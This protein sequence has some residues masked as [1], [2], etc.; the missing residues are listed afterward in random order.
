MASLRVLVFDHEGRPVAFDM[1]HDDLQLYLL[2]DIKDNVS[3]FGHVSG[4]AQRTAQA[5]YDA[6]VAR[7][8]SSATTASPVLTTPGALSLVTT[9]SAPAGRI[10][11]GIAGAA[12]GASASG[13]LPRT[14]P[15]EALHTFTLDSG[16]SPCFVSDGTTLTPLPAPVPVKQAD[17]SR[18]LVLA[19]SSTVLPCLGVSSGSLSGL[20]LP[21][22]STNL[23]S[24]AALQD[25][26]VTTT[27]PGGSSLYTL[28][29]EPPQGCERY[30]LLVVD[31]YSRYTTVF[32][33]RSKGEVVDV[34]IP[35]IPTVHLQLREHFGTDLRVLRLH[36]D[37]G[38]EFSSYLLREFF[39]GRAFSSR[40]R[41]RT[42]LSKMGLLSAALAQSWRSLVPP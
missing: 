27:T 12:L 28:A 15:A 17:P 26:M 38:S 6:V 2:S 24:T 36:S 13:T 3:L 10:C 39:V 7:Y 20:H 29:T 1:W 4:V 30:F 5:L 42:P 33:L 19:R 25:A 35:W 31:D 14:T 21:S 23:V 22:F 40:S 32:P 8:S 41:F 16:A 34:L 9:S 11:L 18:G 37:R